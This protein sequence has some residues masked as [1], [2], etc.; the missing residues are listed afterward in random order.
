ML[1]RAVYYDYLE[2]KLRRFIQICL[3]RYFLDYVVIY[4]VTT[5]DCLYYC[6]YVGME[7][8]SF[9]LADP[10]RVW[11]WMFFRNDVPD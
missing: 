2:I 7:M 4:F 9:S 1:A 8:A 3:T 6:F 11:F 10:G 5:L